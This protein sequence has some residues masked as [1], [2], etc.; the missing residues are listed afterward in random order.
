MCGSNVPVNRWAGNKLRIHPPAR[1]RR[2]DGGS[3]GGSTRNRR[4]DPHP[5]RFARRP[6]PCRGRCTTK[7]VARGTIM[8]EKRKIALTVNGKRYEDEVEVRVT[9]ADFIRGQLGLT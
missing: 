8:G 7:L 1:G 2:R 6:P 4:L 9:L 3:G 5:A